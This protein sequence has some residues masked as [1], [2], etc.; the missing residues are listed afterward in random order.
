MDTS[1]LLTSL[2]LLAL[3]VGSSSALGACGSDSSTAAS[4]PDGGGGQVDSGDEGG[5]R[6]SGPDIG[7][8]LPA[9]AGEASDG[10]SRDSGLRQTDATAMGSDDGGEQRPDSAAPADLTPADARPEDAGEPLDQGVAAPDANT[11]PPPVCESAAAAECGGPVVGR[12]T[13]VDFCDPDRKPASHPRVCEG[14]GEHEPACQPGPNLRECV[15]RY[16]GWAVFDPGGQLST[17]FGVGLEARY[18]FDDLCLQALDPGRLPELACEAMGAGRLDCRY[19][20]GLC[21]CEAASDPEAEHQAFAYEV[22]DNQLTI[23]GRA[24]G[25]FC[26]AYDQLI[27]DFEPFGPEG[28]KSWLLVRAA[29]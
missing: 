8:A 7:T 5:E 15:L 25:T 28:W 29:P 24:R 14:P 3:L 21:T 4:T 11:A 16:G 17:R 9:D 19:E 10:A 2:G 23:D 6:D 1:H 22:V 20:P 12:W 18:R 27:I 13:L 26:S